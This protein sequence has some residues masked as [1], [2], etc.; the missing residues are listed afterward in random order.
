MQ[1]NNGWFKIQINPIFWIIRSLYT[2]TIAPNFINRVL[3]LLIKTLKF[4]LADCK[5]ASYIITIN[6]CTTELYPWNIT[7]NPTY[8]SVIMAIFNKIASSR[9]T[10]IVWWDK[11][12]CTCCLYIIVNRKSLLS[13]CKN[14]WIISE[15]FFLRSCTLHYIILNR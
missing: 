1:T 14:I 5:S 6:I 9:I 2:T 12:I 8:G 4:S 7:F 11:Q 15:L 10:Y 13:I 3:A